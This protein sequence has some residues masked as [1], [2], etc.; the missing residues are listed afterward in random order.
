MEKMT[1]AKTKK[2]LNESILQDIG[3][4]VESLDYGFVTV[5]VQDSK[6]IQIEVTKRKRFD[7]VWRTEEGTEV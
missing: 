7:S 1:N 2:T 6:I 3:E 4:A 5:K